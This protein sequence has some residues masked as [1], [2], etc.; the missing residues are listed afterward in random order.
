MAANITPIFPKGP[1]AKTRVVISTA[2]A[3]RDGTGTIV[4]VIDAA[5]A[6]GA[7]VDG[8]QIKANVT[9]TAGMVRF[10]VHDA[11]NWTLLDEVI[12]TAITVGADTKSFGSYWVPPGGV[13]RLPSG[14]KLG[15]AP[16]NGESF[17]L[18]ADVHTL[19]G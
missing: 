6:D 10:Y 5:G 13:L 9:T 14:Y 3:N 12:V 1:T 18:R 7:Q 15:A 11:A 16:H 19:T 8:V 2:N 4:D 17:H